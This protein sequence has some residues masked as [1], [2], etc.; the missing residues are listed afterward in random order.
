MYYSDLSSL[1]ACFSSADVTR[2]FAS[3]AFLVFFIWPGA[4]YENLK[5]IFNIKITILWEWC[6]F[7]NFVSF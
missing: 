5:L 6:R 3:C 4:L 7:F 1:Q 2:V